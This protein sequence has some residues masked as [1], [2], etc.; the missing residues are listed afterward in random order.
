MIWHLSWHLSE[1]LVSSSLNC[2]QVSERTII[3]G[4]EE[5]LVEPTA[6]DSSH[7]NGPGEHPHQSIA[8][9]LCAMLGGW[10]W[11]GSKLLALCF[12]ALLMVIQCY[13][14]WTSICFTLY[15]VHQMQTR[16]KSALNFW[17]SSLCSSTMTLSHQT[18]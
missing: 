5:L 10:C 15:I 2:T 6:P 1:H 11:S 8:E 13:C 9:S 17:M 14:S 3:S 4:K 12:Q 16:L 7:Q 18:S